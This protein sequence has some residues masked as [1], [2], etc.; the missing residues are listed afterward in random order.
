MSYHKNAY[1]I[2]PLSWIEQYKTSIEGQSHNVFDI[3]E[4]CYGDEPERIFDRSIYLH[5]KFENFNY[6]QSFLLDYAFE[7]GYDCVFN[8]NAD[9]VYAHQWIEKMLPW[10]KKGYDIVSCNFILFEDVQMLKKHEFHNLNIE[11]ELSRDHN[12]LCHPAICYNKTFWEKGNRYNPED[13]KTKD[14][15]MRL[16]KRAIKNSKFI[17][18]PE[19]LCYHRLHQNS[20]CQSSNQ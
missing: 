8:S 12:I 17:I 9:D 10:I 6:T 18:L 4:V 11:E 5:K 7:N 3:L 14:E 19:H 13:V 1:S 16:W 20:V 2:Y 15:D